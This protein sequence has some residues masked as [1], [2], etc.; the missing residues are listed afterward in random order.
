MKCVFQSMEDILV[1]PANII[2]LNDGYKII[3]IKNETI[4][5]DCT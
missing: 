3:R 1:L 4:D 2:L 5:D